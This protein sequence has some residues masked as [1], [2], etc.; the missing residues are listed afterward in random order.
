MSTLTNAFKATAAGLV[1]GGF[2]QVFAT[3]ALASW[4]SLA[5]LAAV[6]AAAMAGSMVGKYGASIDVD[7]GTAPAGAL[8]SI[9]GFIAGTALFWCGS[10]PGA[11]ENNAMLIDDFNASEVQTVNV[12]NQYKDKDFSTLVVPAIKA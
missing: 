6:P 11:D 4:G 2:V 8:G 7:K 1:G 9:G 3:A 12:D 5:L 10:F